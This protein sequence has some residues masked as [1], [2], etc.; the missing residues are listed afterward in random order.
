[1]GE[2]SHLTSFTS[3]EFPNGFGHVPDGARF[4]PFEWCCFQ[5]WIVVIARYLNSSAQWKPWVRVYEM[6]RSAPHAYNDFEVKLVD[7]FTLAHTR[8]KWESSQH[9]GSWVSVA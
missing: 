5:Q 6:V 3:T 8:N 2:G 4:E 7:H 1:M 9:S